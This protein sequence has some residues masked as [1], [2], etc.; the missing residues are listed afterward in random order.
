[1][2]VRQAAVSDCT[3][4]IP[5]RSPGANFPPLAHR[6]T[7]QSVGDRST[8]KGQISQVLS[9]R[10]PAFPNRHHDSGLHS[11]GQVPRT[12]S[13]RA[14][15]S[16]CRAPANAGSFL[17]KTLTARP[18]RAD[19]RCLEEHERRAGGP[20]LRRTRRG[21]RRRA[22]QMATA[23]HRRGIGSHGSRSPRLTRR[24][25]ADATPAARAAPGQGPRTRWFP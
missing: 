18:C 23:I 5:P 9:P 8:A 22:G 16:D 21:A 1:M 17:L 14:R 15:S 4:T 11:A 7:P 3:R 20:G 25:D 13:N 2:V 6:P 12:P 24:G 19:A 10:P